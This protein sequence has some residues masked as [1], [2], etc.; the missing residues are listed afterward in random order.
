MEKIDIY[1]LILT[2][3]DKYEVAD[4][5]RFDLV[6]NKI[7]PCVQVIKG[8]DSTYKWENKIVTDKEIIV[9]AKVNASKLSTAKDRIEKLHNYE[10]PEIISFN[11][12]II[13]RA[14]RDWFN[15]SS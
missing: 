9:L 12:N 3:T 14:Y 6:S 1:K 5:I 7:A 2:T 13:N 4:K 15:E 10:C 11:F 8:V